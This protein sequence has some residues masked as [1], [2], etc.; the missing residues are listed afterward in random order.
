MQDQG[1]T[2]LVS[3]R[4]PIPGKKLNIIKLF[5]K[6]KQWCTLSQKRFIRFQHNYSLLM[7][8]NTCDLILIQFMVC[9]VTWNIT[10][11]VHNGCAQQWC[12]WYHSIP[13]KIVIGMEKMQ[14]SNLKALRA[15]D[16]F[17]SSV[18]AGTSV[19]KLL[20]SD[21]HNVQYK[22]IKLVNQFLLAFWS[23]RFTKRGFE[24]K[25]TLRLSSANMFNRLF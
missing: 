15:T 1:S 23:S 18:G 6:K 19:G 25:W 3:Q 22:P 16:D 4:P 17:D 5:L 20:S 8:I 21:I 12:L 14:H 9:L 2:R 10:L 13:W 7:T 24:E 11:V